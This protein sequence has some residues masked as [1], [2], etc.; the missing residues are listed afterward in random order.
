M[1][2]P[3]SN[4]PNPDWK[5]TTLIVA[6][7]GSSRHPGAKHVHRHIETLR[8]QNL[9]A[10][11][12]AGFLKETP[13]L[14]DVL[15]AIRTDQAYIVPMVTGR[16][17]ITDTLIPDM[18]S[19]SE[20]PAD[21]KLCEP[22]GN[23]PMLASI[24]ADRVRGVLDDNALPKNDSAFLLAAHGNKSN[25]DVARDGVAIADQL[26]RDLNISSAAAFIE[27]APL[28]TDWSKLLHETNIIVMPFLV[29]GGFHGLKDVPDMLGLGTV[30]ESAGVTGPY[31]LQGRSLWCC[32]PVGNETAIADII[33]Q[34]V[35]SAS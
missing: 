28:I 15:S 6:A 14:S 19:G 26:G 25:P 20:C 33:I 7:H 17:Y 3:D 13:L 4:P 31:E 5:T 35:D 12:Q 21:V 2:K 29:G 32:P 10:D 18:I 34:R 30:D 16:G 22:V 11:V 24:M 23:H 8:Q 1:S 9:F 27:H